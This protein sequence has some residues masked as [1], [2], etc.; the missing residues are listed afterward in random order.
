[1]LTLLSRRYKIKTSE[2]ERV[3]TRLISSGLPFSSPEREEDGLSFVSSFFLKKEIEGILRGV[4]ATLTYEPVGVLAAL[5]FFRKRMGLIFGAILSLFLIYLSTFYVWSVRIEGNEELSDEAILEAM[6]QCGFY[7]GVLKSRVDVNEI[8]NEVLS[9]CHE[10][11]FFSINIHGMVADVV[12]HER[13]RGTRPT[14]RSLPYNLVADFDGVIVSAVILDGQTMFNIGDAVFKG[15]L[16]VSGIMDSTSEGF[17]LRQAEGKVYARTFRTIELSVPYEYYEK[18]EIKREEA[19][20][21]R[22][23]GKSLGKSVGDDSG[24]YDVSRLVEEVTLFGLTLPF[25]IETSVAHYYTNEKSVISETE[26]RAKLTCDYKKYISTELDS[27]TILDERFSFTDKGDALFLT[28]E[29]TAIENIAV[30]ER[31]ITENN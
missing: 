23:L 1:M 16:L 22:V 7:E 17:R 4:S 26:A 29:V 21:I 6:A 8:Q 19:R 12:V 10:L 11:S 9:R 27:A 14:E 31:I 2:R 3:L 25:S 15:E 30:K 5:C 20:R 28:A 13:V 24:S 18:R